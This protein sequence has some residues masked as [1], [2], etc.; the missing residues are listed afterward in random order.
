M[1]S[2]LNDLDTLVDIRDICVD[3]NLPRQERIAEYVRQ[4]KNPYHF[5]CG[6]FVVTAH[7]A[8]D[9]PPLEDCLRGLVA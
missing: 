7:F 9:G 5:R 8:V 3:K 1:H 6:K 4:I 2:S